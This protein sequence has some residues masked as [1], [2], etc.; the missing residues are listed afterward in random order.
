MENLTSLEQSFFVHPCQKCGACC[1]YFRVTFYWREGEPSEHNK[2]VPPDL[3]IDNGNSLFRTLKG[4]EINHNPKC[5][6]L[7]GTIGVSAKCRVY[8]NRPSPCRNFEA[9]Y[10]NGQKNP[11]CDEAR[12]AHGLPHLNKTDWI[13]K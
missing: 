12:K 6:A 10:E 7:N 9:S 11:R 13:K 3:W 2:A 8:E 1:A 5:H 4:T